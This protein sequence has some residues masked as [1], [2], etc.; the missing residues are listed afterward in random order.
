MQTETLLYI[1]LSGI[2]ALL[3]ALFQYRYKTKHKSRTHLVLTFLRFLGLFALL[4]LLVNPKFDR[5]TTYE[6]K[7]NLI[8]A[9][10][11]S[12][13]IK[14]LKQDNTA[15]KAVKTIT[16]TS[17]LQDKF[18]IEVYTFDKGINATD[19]LHFNAKETN[20]DKALGQLSELYKNR[21]APVVLLSDGNQTFGSD[22][23]VANTAYKQPVYP[24]ILGDT[25][26]YTDLKVQRLQVNRYAFLKNKF[27]VEAVLVYQGN[28]KVNTKFYVKQG[29]AVVYSK[30]LRFSK[31]QTSHII[32]FTLPAASVGV[33]TY[34]AVLEPLESEK[35]TINN[36]KNFAVEVIDQKTKIAL[37]SQFKHPDI[38]VIKKSIESNEQRS[39]EVLNPNKALQKLNDYQLIILYQPDYTFAKLITA[40]AQEKKNTFTIIGPKTN[41]SV[42]NR[43][44]DLYY[45]EITRETEDFQPK[46]NSNYAPFLV[47]DLNFESF[48]PLKGHFGDLTFNVSF[49]TLLEKTILGVTS[50]QP[51]LATLEH[52]G[53]REALLLGEDIW[54]WRAQSFLNRK[55]FSAFDD[56]TGKLIQ[57]LATSKQK[58]RLNIDYKSFYNG[59]SNLVIS[60]Q[61]FDKNYQFDA[62]SALEIIV[63]DTLSKTTQRIPLVLKN[64]TYQVDLSGLAPSKYNF[65]IQSKQQNIAKS[66]TFEVLEYNI[67]Q[68]FLNANVTK[69]QQL[70][71]NT[72]AKSYFESEI[73][74]LIKTILQ[75]E[76][77]KSIQ[78]QTKNTIP[79]VDWKYL[80]GIIILAFAAEWFLRKYNGLI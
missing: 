63:T 20:I 73:N 15:L 80:L 52:Q 13:S 30:T 62:R 39:V 22:Y 27:P 68:Q 35:N 69:L 79:L 38:G 33:A 4:L 53:R 47:N 7:P 54:R 34:K 14:H 55:T 10:D 66:G 32:N 51:L 50:S 18:N 72:K 16:E 1:I 77:F 58:S 60:A 29:N 61:I 71:T 41:L 37:V 59:A 6:E 11:N 75:N 44:Q 36:T 23:A 56:F 74:T 2:I 19:S 12:N 26:T 49:E 40:T 25:V 76:N 3:V 9:V 70:A 42:L 5:T 57:Y 78:K 17:E 65:T 67:E 64:N 24:V 48:P 43:N 28:A 31:T 21:I 8:L 45:H 46:L